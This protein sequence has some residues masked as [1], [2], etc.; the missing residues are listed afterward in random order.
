VVYGWPLAGQ[1]LISCTRR[2]IGSALLL[3]LWTRAR[4]RNWNA[5]EVD[6][7]CTYRQR[8]SRLNYLY[9]FYA[10]GGCWMLLPRY[11]LIAIL[12]PVPPEFAFPHTHPVGFVARRGYGYAGMRTR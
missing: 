4:H 6:D 11:N 12:A 8:I 7:I 10:R 2:R 1:Y 3:K 9:A 5:G